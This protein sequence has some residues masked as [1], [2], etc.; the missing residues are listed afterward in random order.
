MPVS[1][2]P[3]LST[4]KDWVRFLISDRDVSRAIL[5]DT[6]IIAVLAEEANKYLAAARCGEILLTRSGGVVWKQVGELRIKYDDTETEDSVYRSY[7][8]RLREKG[9]WL[10][11]PKPRTFANL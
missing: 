3:G 7:L 5:D 9:A 10:V 2:D 8:R 6:E 4:D 11:L 1:Y